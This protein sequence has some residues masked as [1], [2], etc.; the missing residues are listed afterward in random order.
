MARA[1]LQAQGGRAASSPLL[2][3]TPLYVYSKTWGAN[4]FQSYC[5]TLSVP[6]SANAL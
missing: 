6:T 1:A 2:V 3:I 5:M 4:I